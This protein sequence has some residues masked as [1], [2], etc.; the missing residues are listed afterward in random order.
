MTYLWKDSEQQEAAEG[1]SS[2]W[3]WGKYLAP[4]IL[5]VIETITLLWRQ[6]CVP[7][8]S[9][10]GFMLVIILKTCF[11]LLGKTG[12]QS[13][14]PTTIDTTDSQN[15]YRLSME[16]SIHLR[17]IQGSIGDNW[18]SAAPPQPWY[19]QTG[20][21]ERWNN[22]H[23][24]LTNTIVTNPWLKAAVPR[25]ASNAASP[26]HEDIMGLDEIFNRPMNDIL[27]DHALSDRKSQTPTGKQNRPKP[28][29]QHLAQ[30]PFEATPK[31]SNKR[32]LQAQQTDSSAYEYSQPL[33]KADMAHTADNSQALPAANLSTHIPEEY[34]GTSIYAE[35]PSFDR[36]HLAKTGSGEPAYQDTDMSSSNAAYNE[37]YFE[38]FET[39]HQ[40]DPWNDIPTHAHNNIPPS[41]RAAAHSPEGKS[42]R[43]KPLPSAKNTL[44]AIF[45]HILKKKAP[46]YPA[47]QVP[48]FA[49]E[50]S[51]PP[52][53]LNSAPAS[54]VPWLAPEQPAK[55][56]PVNP[57][58]QPSAKQSPV[59]RP[60]EKKAQP[61]MPSSSPAP[62]STAKPEP[63][64]LDH[65][66]EEDLN[67][68]DYMLQNNRILSK[69]ISNL[70]D[71]YFRNASQEEEPHL[72]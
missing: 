3:L 47:Q 41:E 10:F 29:H 15:S 45:P 49:Q 20:K 67:G 44:P 32:H 17:K 53:A 64:R 68:F 62:L 34:P 46:E 30:S 24:K 11:G 35:N 69:S 72:Y 36:S 70:V 1:A 61:P 25:T 52:S 26:L 59:V 19:C 55:P 54:D 58:I 57:S 37:P 22:A 65:E 42:Q 43:I 38:R 6:V 39:V 27:M 63:L 50:G 60:V 8:F 40:D 21:A 56:A 12:E 33:V 5:D 7:A 16:S 66:L 18:A 31:A 2:I 14:K 4:V 9:A 51:N 28:E 71:N 48:W 23:R 13:G